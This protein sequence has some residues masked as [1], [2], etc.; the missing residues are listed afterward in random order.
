GADGGRIDGTATDASG[1]RGHAFPGAQVVLVP[2]AERRGHP[3]QYR[4]VSSDE[5]GKFEIRGIPP[6]D[7][8]LFAWENVEERAWLNSE[9][10]MKFFDT[11]LPVSVPAKSSNTVQLPVMP[12]KK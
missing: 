10:M 3:D 5:E 2:N 9:F 4:A 7:Y 11:G 8:Q 12:E 1:A 6:G